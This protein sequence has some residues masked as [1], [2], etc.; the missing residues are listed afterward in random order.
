MANFG[1][2]VPHVASRVK[3]KRERVR[4]EPVHEL[5]ST[6]SSRPDL[7]E[8]F[9]AV[10][11]AL[12][13]ILQYEF[14]QLYTYDPEIRK[15]RTRAMHFP[16]GK[17]LV[18][19][20]LVAPIENT[21]AGWVYLHLQPLRMDRPDTMRTPNEVVDRLMREGVRSG[22]CVPVVYCDHILGVLSVGSSREAAFHKGDEALLCAAAHEL[23][24]AMESRLTHD[25]LHHSESGLTEAVLVAGAKA[26]FGRCFEELVRRNENM[27]LRL[28]MRITRNE[29]D[30]EDAMQEAFVKAHHHLGQFR[31]DSRFATWL[32]SIAVNEALLQLRRRLLKQKAPLNPV[33]EGNDRIPCQAKDWKPTPEQRYA[34]I[35]LQKAVSEAIGKLHPAYRIVLILRDIEGCSIKETSQLLGLSLP[36]IKSRLLRAR[37]KLRTSLH[38]RFRV[39]ALA[40]ALRLS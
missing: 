37:L 14:S 31:G 5:T 24:L 29:E 16:N 22:C 25:G 33:K 36:A 34:R 15:L 27:I 7:R 10:T 35:E 4:P 23:A 2:G 11:A 38:P 20:G 6:F 17:G 18:R 30:A 26:G 21:P 9:A 40:S 32:G 39:G 19:E 28:A 3:L 12:R 13:P 1:P 8:L